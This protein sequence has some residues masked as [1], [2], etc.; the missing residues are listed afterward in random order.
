MTEKIGA[1]ILH[2]NEQVLWQG[3]PGAALFRAWALHKVV[4]PIGAAMFLTVWGALFIPG[5][6]AAVHGFKDINLPSIPIALMVV[7]P[8]VTCGASWHCWALIQSYQYTVTDQRVIF[9]GGIFRRI[10]RSVH[11]D[12]ITDVQV[13]QNFLEQFFDSSTLEI[14]T[15]GT[16]SMTATGSERAEITFP[17]L[18]DLHVPEQLVIGKLNRLGR[19]ANGKE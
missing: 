17:G 15:P 10:R 1:L 13:S 4:F 16:S 6:W 2:E 19:H 9:V 5:I 7:V 14:F 18:T 11:Y 8:I 3:K 12:K